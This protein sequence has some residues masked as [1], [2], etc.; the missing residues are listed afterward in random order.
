MITGLL[1]EMKNLNNILKLRDHED[2]NKY[3]NMES[4][5]DQINSRKFLTK[6]NILHMDFPDENFDLIMAIGV[7]PHVDKDDTPD[8]IAE[9]LRLLKPGQVLYFN[10]RADMAKWNTAKKGRVFRDNVL[11]DSA[12]GQ[13]NSRY[14]NTYTR[15]E[16]EA[17]IDHLQ[18]MYPDYEI[19]VDEEITAHPDKN[20]PP[21]LNIRIRKPL[22]EYRNPTESAVPV[23][24]E[25]E[26]EI[27]A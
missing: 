21:F 7:L 4:I 18:E 23:D 22:R 8:A 26:Q 1:K 16:F 14:F 17:L 19:I 15:R 11:R 24:S 5:A 6:D 9:N 12:T 20:K 25:M 3:F 10:L 2:E 13:E 27:A